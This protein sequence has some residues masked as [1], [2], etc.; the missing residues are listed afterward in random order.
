MEPGKTALEQAEQLRVAV[1][2]FVRRGRAED[3]MPGGQAAVLGYLDRTGPVS[4][5]DLAARVRVRHQSMA[6]TVQLLHAAGLV[7][8]DRDPGDHRRVRV[9]LT[10]AGLGELAADRTR[11]ATWIAA[12][13]RDH[14]TPDE[15]AVYQQ[16]PAI[17][18]KLSSAS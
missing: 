11:R 16:I 9:G 13:A 18:A 17:L 6:R 3:A 14:L 10:P 4:I 1:G 2:E 5:T 15:R 8:V 7:I 12:A